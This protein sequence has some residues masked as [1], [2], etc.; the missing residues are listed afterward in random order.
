MV[1]DLADV[2]IPP[3]PCPPAK[4]SLR[5]WFEEAETLDHLHFAPPDESGRWAT[6]DTDERREIVL[7]LARQ[8]ASFPAIAERVNATIEDVA[9]ALAQTQRTVPTIIAIEQLEREH[10]DWSTWRLARAVGA[11]QGYVAWLLVHLGRGRPERAARAGAGT[12]HG[13]ETY[14]K[15]RELREK[16]WSWPRIGKTFGLSAG[17]VYQMH[18]R[19]YGKA[20]VSA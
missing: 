7:R 12:V 1:D 11:G 19:R 13:D 3:Y 18:R 10:S 2:V 8:G 15:I 6:A 14:E 16:G 5:E 9:L 4:H 17:S 20:E